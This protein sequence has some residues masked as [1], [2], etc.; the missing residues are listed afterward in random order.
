VWALR[1]VSFEVPRGSTLGV[2]GRNGAGKTTLLSILSRV[3]VPTEGRALVAGKASALLEV[4]TGFHA[5]LTGRE[6]VYLNGAVL[7]MKRREIN[8][9]FDEIVAFSE[10]ERFIDTPVKRYSS[11]MALRLAF[12]VAAHLEP[13]V[14]LVDEVLA[15]GDASFQAKCLGKMGEVTGEGRTVVLVSHNMPTIASLADRCIWL[16]QGGIAAEGEAAT[17]IE[18]YLGAVRDVSKGGSAQLE[19][20]PRPPE[21]P[22]PR[23]VTF[24]RVRLLDDRGGERG[25]FFEGEPIRIEVTIEVRRPVDWFE[26]RCYAKTVEGVW[27]FAVNSGKQKIALG[28]GF[29]TCEARLD[30][31]YLRPGSYRLDLGMQSVVPQD[32]VEDAIRLRIEFSHEGYDDPA[33]RSDMGLVRFDY[34]WSPLRLMAGAAADS[35]LGS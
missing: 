4:G 27:L 10:I 30:P 3:T 13:D 11:G 21:H 18:R 26:L 33:W 12:S 7:G 28:R 25:V 9:K 8:R 32:V 14:L 23:E 19:D 20:R 22:S 5:D 29:Y 24:H 2:I 1:D 31:S 35:P 15:V 6:N 34:A 17:V 16:D